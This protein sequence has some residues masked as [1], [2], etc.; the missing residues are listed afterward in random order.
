MMVNDDG[1]GYDEGDEV[2]PEDDR[3]TQQDDPEADVIPHLRLGV[4]RGQV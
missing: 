1:G 4:E 2:D 3:V